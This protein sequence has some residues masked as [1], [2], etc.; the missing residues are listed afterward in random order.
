MLPSLL[1]VSVVLGNCWTLVADITTRTCYGRVRTSKQSL[2]LEVWHVLTALQ[3]LPLLVD[4]VEKICEEN[5]LR[6]DAI[7]MRMTG[8]PNGCAR[9]YVAGLLSIPLA[10]MS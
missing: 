3:Y 6:N 2:Y 8:C 5:G 10:R 4:K 9:P 7:V 1:V